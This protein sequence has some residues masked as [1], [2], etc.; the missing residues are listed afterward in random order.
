M[1]Y[2]ALGH[3]HKPQRLSANDSIRYSGSPIPLSFSEK[4]YKHQVVV[5]EINNRNF[6]HLEI[7]EIPIHTP[8]LSIPNQN[9]ILEEVLFELENLTLLFLLIPNNIIH[10]F[11]FLIHLPHNVL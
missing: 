8:L 10:I 2:I 6:E 5:F 3:I 1:K 4:T 11:L 9:K 7:I